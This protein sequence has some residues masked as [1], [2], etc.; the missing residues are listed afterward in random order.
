LISQASRSTFSAL[1]EHFPAKAA[2]RTVAKMRQN[3][4]IEQ[5]P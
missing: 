2:S 5:E 4:R 1:L 3:K